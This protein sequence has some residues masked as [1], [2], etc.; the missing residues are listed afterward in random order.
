MHATFGAI[1]IKSCYLDE[2]EIMGSVIRCVVY[3]EAREH[4]VTTKAL[5]TRRL[6]GK[7]VSN[8]SVVIWTTEGKATG[9][10][11]LLSWEV[12]GKIV[13]L[14]GFPAVFNFRLPSDLRYTFSQDIRYRNLTIY[15]NGCNGDR[16]PLSSRG[17]TA[18]DAFSSSETRGQCG[19][20]M[21]KNALYPIIA[22]NLAKFYSCFPL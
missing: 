11:Q 22:Q 18:H 15:W 1:F 4:L 20:K 5:G 17:L 19:D 16:F 3:L 13:D 9:R 6:V 21:S 12:P 8:I 2:R 14:K 10:S 7:M